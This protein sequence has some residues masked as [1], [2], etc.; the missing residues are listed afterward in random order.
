MRGGMGWAPV[1][2]KPRRLQRPRDESG[3][4]VLEWARNYP[5]AKVSRRELA[6]ILSQILT[7]DDRE[8][9]GETGTPEGG[10]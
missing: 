5:E 9:D 7:V 6:A 8:R 1:R 10:A 4:S 3:Q 2:R